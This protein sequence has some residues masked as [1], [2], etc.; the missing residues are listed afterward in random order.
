MKRK[1]VAT[2][3][4]ACMAASLMAGCGQ[5]SGSTAASDG[6]SAQTSTAGTSESASGDPLDADGDGAVDNPEDVVVDENKLVLWSLFAG[7]DGEYFDSLIEDYN[8]KNPPKQV[9]SILAATMADDYYTKLQTAVVA[10][11]GP[12]I[13]ISHASKLLEFVD[14]GVVEPL[15]D[16]LDELGVD[17]TTMYPQANLDAVTFDG[18]IY[19]IPLDT[20]AEILW[21]N[22]DILEKA[23]VP[24]NEDGT[25]N[26]SS[27]D[28]FKAIL[29]QCKAVMGEGQSVISLPSA[30]DDPYRVWWA[31]YFQMGGTPL[32]SDDGTQVTMDKDIAVQAADFV[33]SLYEDGYVAEGITDHQKFFQGGNAA[34]MFGGT[35]C[36]GAFTSTE[37]LNVGCMSWPQLFGQPASW[38]DSHTLILPVS[39]DRTEEETLAAV[40]FMVSASTDEGLIW[41][42]S[43]QIPA[44][45]SVNESEEFLSMPLR[46]NYVSTLEDA[47][48]PTKNPHFF[49]MKVG[50]IESLDA[51]WAGTTDAAGAIDSLYAVLESNLS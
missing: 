12:D 40:Q 25:L 9:Q 17:I 27:W 29:D 4:S 6:A 8:S 26:I 18:Q 34:F 20:H 21:Y 16:Y 30:S 38:A 32:V 44:A 5:S 19:A 46:Q 50:M 11:S 47:V 22:T 35:W 1:V 31:T 24:I 28:D 51:L 42:Q 15:N 23:G 48:M 49:A 45:K 43:G 39:A 37:G 7:G 41:A 36:V 3:L 13:G 2:L 10:K 33:R 14:Q